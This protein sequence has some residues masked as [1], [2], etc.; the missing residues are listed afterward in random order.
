[1]A[2]IDDTKILFT[3]DAEAKTENKLLDD[4]INID[5]DILK[6]GHHGSNSSSSERFLSNATPEYAVISVGEDNQYFHHSL[7]S[8]NQLL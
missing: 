7:P 4:N 2:E 5:C 3:G 8:R 1:M 6:V